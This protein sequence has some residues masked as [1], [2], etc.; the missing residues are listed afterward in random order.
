MT[1][2]QDPFEPI[3]R[4]TLAEAPLEQ[5]PIELPSF[6]SLDAH[7]KQARAELRDGFAMAALTGLLAYPGGVGS[8]GQCAIT[9]YKY[10]DAMLEARGDD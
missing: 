6:R 2:E 3:V 8:H 4:A 9:A 1:E 7:R 10:A 5:G